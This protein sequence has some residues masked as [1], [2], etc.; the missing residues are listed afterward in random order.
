MR[1][2]NPAFL[3]SEGTAGAL[4]QQFLANPQLMQGVMGMFGGGGEALCMGVPKGTPS[5][6]M[7]NPLT[8]LL[9]GAR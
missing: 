2:D 3:T 4:V 1:P 7:P 6:P 9:P 5:A 8:G